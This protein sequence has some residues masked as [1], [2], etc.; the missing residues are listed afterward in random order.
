MMN[1]PGSTSER[2]LVAPNTPDTS[3]GGGQP[4]A[5]SPP[6]RRAGQRSPG[7]QTMTISGAVLREPEVSLADVHRCTGLF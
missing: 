1:I 7:A 2:D 3:T 4:H 5:L 6:E